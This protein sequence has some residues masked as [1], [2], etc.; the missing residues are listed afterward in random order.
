MITYNIMHH[1]HMRSKKVR[2]AE[3]KFIQSPEQ[4]QAESHGQGYKLTRDYLKEMGDTM[5]LDN[6]ETPITKREEI[7][8]IEDCI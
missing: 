5:G 6:P 1:Y 7:N 2:L 3:V 8:G 4:G